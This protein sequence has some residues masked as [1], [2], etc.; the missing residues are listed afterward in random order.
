MRLRITDS[1]RAL[2]L[3]TVFVPMISLC[4]TGCEGE[5]KQG[6]VAETPQAVDANKN[7]ED[8]MK[9]QGKA[10]PKK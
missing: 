5:A 4:L 10:A 2:G 3:L 9:N 8:F 7:M 6:P 1:V